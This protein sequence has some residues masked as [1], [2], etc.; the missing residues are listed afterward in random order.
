MRN[1]TGLL[2]VLSVLSISSWAQ[3]I[4][5]EILGT[6]TDQSGAA[7]AGAKIRATN[8]DTNISKDA[9]TGS[10]GRFRITLLNPGDYVI[11]VERDGFSRYQEGP[12]VLALNQ[13]AEFKVGLK[14]GAVS[15]T[16]S[17]T[18]EAPVINTTNAEVS[19]T[20]EA[21]RISELPLAVNRNMLNLA[22]NVPGVSQISSGQSAF[23]SGI[24]MAVNGMRV[25]SNNFMID[26]QDVNDP[27]VT[28]ST[29]GM[30]NPDVV[31]EMRV[32]TNQFAAEY[33]RAAGSVV[34]IVTKSGTNQFHGS[35][36]IFNNNRVFNTRSNLDKAANLQTTPFRNETQLGGTMGGPIKKD[37]TFF[38]GSYQR[39]WDRRLSSGSA[40]EGA[41]TAEGKAL[42]QPFASRPAV[43][44]LLD[45]LPAASAPNGQF[46]QVVTGG[47]TIR[48]PLGRLA[49]TA[50]RTYDDTQLSGRGDH[51][52]NDKHSIGGRYLYQ[53]FTDAGGGQV[54]PPGNTT[55]V[56]NRNQ[57]ANIFV[58]SSLRSNLFSEFRVSYTRQAQETTA[59]DVRSQAIPSIEV[60]DLGLTG[61]NAATSRTGI[62][63]AVNLPQFRKS[64][65]YQIQH[66]IG[67]LAGAH[68][69]KFGYD[70]RRNQTASFFV[71]TTRGRLVYNTL[72]DLVDDVAQ[73]T[74]INGPIRGGQI[75]QYY[76][77]Y[78]YF[79]FAQD[80]FRIRPSLTLTYGLRY[81]A[82]GNPFNNLTPVNQRILA[83]NNNDARY[84]FTAP[85][86]DTNNW[87]P[88]VGVNY[89]LP[90]L[91]RLTGDNTVIRGGYA[92][93]YDFAFINIALNI[94]S[95]FPFVNSFNLPARTPNSYNSLLTALNNAVNPAVLTRTNVAADF[96]SPSADQFS[97]GIQ[98]K[99]FENYSLTVTYVGTRGN[100]LFQ[101]N[102]GNIP[103][104]L[105]LNSI[106]ANGNYNFAVSQRQDPTRAVTRTRA[107]TAESVYHS[108][109]TS[110]E[111]RYSRGLALGAHYTWS[112]YIDTASEVFNPAVNGDIAIA[113]DP[114]NL[115]NDRAR[116][117]YD[118]PHRFSLTH[119]YEIPT[120]GVAGKILGS[121]WQLSGFLTFQSGA[122]FTPLNGT[123]PFLRN[124]GIDGLVGNAVRPNY[125]GG[126]DVSR[127]SNADLFALWR[128]G[129]RYFTPVVATAA[130]VPGNLQPGQ[131]LNIANSP[132]GFG[133]AG[134][135]TLRGDGIGQYDFSL[136]KLTRI[137]ER[138][139]LQLRM[140]VY[141]LTNSR[142][143]GIP[144]SRI[145]SANFLN[146]W[147]T[148]GGNRRIQLGVRYVF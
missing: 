124:S 79:F 111:K 146:K 101:T 87:Q 127:T 10:E 116:S 56:P 98:R 78:D 148:D 88:R 16:V 132:L 5:S 82:P 114:F 91:G 109:Q 65:T 3:S 44:A 147:G 83:A 72:Q 144:E 45:Y 73:S 1:L 8:Q 120:K 60:N 30:N 63:L 103:T 131:T 96:R 21:K 129:T 126:V 51:R 105:V 89:R 58:N 52:F 68:N 20:F 12:F 41:P 9:V 24:S 18:S 136:A 49:G 71:P 31:A 90:N 38:F 48:V 94:F 4:N 142:N 40:I 108:M 84:G 34:N 123:D 139:Q 70:L 53:D 66:N 57:A 117:T 138:Q 143:F 59:Q 130:T 22:L 128:S 113:Q 95:A 67:W 81:E 15:E 76:N 141:N 19:S 25:R 47:Q 26:G 36:F 35:G 135:S 133:S 92:R 80:E 97:F 17:V 100:S 75:M 55:L 64:N 11:T 93:T 102:D 42:L 74:Q 50:G 107:N 115:K 99:M 86:R 14:V 23:A 112:S 119:T 121:G 43:K 118:R 39:W 134:R 7:V 85:P 13:A 28:G 32:I 77:Y 104:Q 106:A 6:V 140:D 61:F 29:Q 110:F 62:G 27:S 37:R 46:S 145:N 33:G 2:A 69:I 54:T 137:T 122:P 125:A